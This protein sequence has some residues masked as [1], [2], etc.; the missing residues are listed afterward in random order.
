MLQRTSNLLGRLIAI[1]IETCLAC[2]TVG[3]TVLLI[4]II[5]RDS[6]IYVVPLFMVGKFYSNSMLAVGSFPPSGFRV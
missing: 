3:I 2:T 6:M 1:T 4:F 5:S